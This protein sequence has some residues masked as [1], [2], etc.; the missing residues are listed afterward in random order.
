MMMCFCCVENGPWAEDKSGQRVLYTQSMDG[1]NWTNTTGD[2]SNILFPIIK[3][4]S[5][6]A[7]LFAGPPTHINGA[8]MP[9]HGQD[10][11]QGLQMVRNYVYGRV[12]WKF[13][14]ICTLVTVARRQS[15]TRAQGQG[16]L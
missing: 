14:V 6:A 2:E 3:T 8:N 13:M 12:L 15:V 10:S 9:E 5:Q 4:S 7:A 16:V 1:E 11:R